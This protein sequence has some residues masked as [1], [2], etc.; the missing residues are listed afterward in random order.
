MRSFCVALLLLA[1]SPLSSAFAKESPEPDPI[2]WGML[3]RNSGCV[4]FAEGRHTS[5]M[6]WGV[7]VTTK[8]VGKLTVIEAQNS[9][10][11]P[12]EYLETQEVMNSP[13]APRTAGQSQ[14]RQDSGEVLA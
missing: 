5:G 1:A 11:D 12:K 13:D 10:I 8:T 7:A 2:A 14:V 3:S 4:I 6:F 9:T